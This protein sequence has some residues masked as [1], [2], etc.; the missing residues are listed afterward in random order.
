[1]IVSE[2]IPNGKSCRREEK[3]DEKGKSATTAK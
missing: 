3:K 2:L 1:M